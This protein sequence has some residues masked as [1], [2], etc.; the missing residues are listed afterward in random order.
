MEGMG[1]VDIFATKG[2]E[3]LIVIGFLAALVFY[4]KVIGQTEPEAAPVRALR[5]VARGWFSVPRDYLFHPGH[6]WAAQE[7]DSLFR[8]GMDD[9]AQQLLGEPSGLD[10][11]NPGTRLRQGELGWKV[12]VGSRA[13]RMLSPVDGVVEAVNTDLRAAP[14]LVNEDPYSGGWLMKVRVPDPGRPARNLLPAD[15]ARQWL[16]GAAEGLRTMWSGELGMALPDG[17][18]PV[19][20]FG[21]A[22][23]ADQWHELAEEFFLSAGLP[24]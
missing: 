24:E 21:R 23:A 4:W 2:I 7:Q 18:A 13:V 22:L 8:V 15:A 1:A 20:G 9:F 3:Y 12:K 11:P 6:A 10:L 16:D 17:G 5:S 14:G 19:M